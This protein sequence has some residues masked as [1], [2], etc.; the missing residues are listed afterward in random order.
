MKTYWEVVQLHA[1]LNSALNEGGWS[2]S[3]PDRFIPLKIPVPS[4]EKVSGPQNL[5]IRSGEYK[6]HSFP[7]PAWNRSPV[8]QS[9][10]WSLPELTKLTCTN[11]GF[12]IIS[13]PTLVW[14]FLQLIFTSQNK[15]PGF[16][17]MQKI[18]G[19]TLC[20]LV[21]LVLG[22]SRRVTSSIVTDTSRIISL[23]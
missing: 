12:L 6:K 8:V 13:A 3:R 7:V 15:E 9:V 14:K 11:Q 5:S 22:C 10:A 18:N 17:H 4:E 1:L 23:L 19:L 2:V 16:T 20:A 21:F